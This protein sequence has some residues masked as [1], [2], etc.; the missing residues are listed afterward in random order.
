MVLL[1]EFSANFVFDN[2]MSSTD[3]LAGFCGARF[4]DLACMHLL[5]GGDFK[6]KCLEGSPKGQTHIMLLESAREA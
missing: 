4:E 2:L 5:K 3:R 6:T 1:L